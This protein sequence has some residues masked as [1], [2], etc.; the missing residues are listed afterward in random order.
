[1]HDSPGWYGKLPALGDFASRRLPQNFIQPWDAW[2]QQGLAASRATLGEAWL[3]TY[4]TSSIWRFVLAA[5]CL[6]PGAWAGI[7][8]PSVDRV[9]RY[10]PLTIAAPFASASQLEEWFAALESAAHAG[11]SASEISAFDNALHSIA[12]PAASGG[13]LQLSPLEIGSLPA[14]QASQ[15]ANDLLTG[16]LTGHSL[17][18]ACNAA[19]RQ[20]GFVCHG[21]PRPDVFTCMLEYTPG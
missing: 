9:G 13:P 19:G 2:L 16:L 6:G 21:M 17:W 11:L 1:M 12:P 3:E 15:A 7:L 10:F 8:V 14:P 5:E 20:S 4:L 18:L